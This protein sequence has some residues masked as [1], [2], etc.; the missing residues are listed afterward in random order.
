M[1]E[2]TINYFIIRN[3]SHNK[4]ETKYDNICYF[5]TKTTNTVVT[6]N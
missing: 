2:I 3:I 1:P 4:Y 6:N 5:K